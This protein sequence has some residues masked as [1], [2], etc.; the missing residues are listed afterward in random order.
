MKKYAVLLLILSVCSLGYGKGKSS[1][2]K[3]SNSCT[4]NKIIVNYKNHTATYCKNGK[5]KVLK[6]EGSGIDGDDWQLEEVDGVSLF[7]ENN[8][9]LVIIKR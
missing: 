3:S 5:K 6:T 1:R 7:D 9:R 4:S 2:K 8:P